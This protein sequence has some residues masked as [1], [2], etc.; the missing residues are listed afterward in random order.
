VIGGPGACIAKFIIPETMQSFLMQ[1]TCDDGEI[2]A[3][4]INPLSMMPTG[5]CR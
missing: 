3:P 1:S 4:C 2:C 5:A